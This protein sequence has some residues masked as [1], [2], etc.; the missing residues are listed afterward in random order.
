[1]DAQVELLQALADPTRLRL[2]NLLM[3]TEEVCVCELVD[4]LHLAQYNVSRHLQ[5]LLEVDLLEHR[6]SGKWIYYRIKRKLTPYQR[7]LL[8]AVEQLREEREEFRKDESRAVGRL[9]LRRNG[10][11]CVGLVQRIN[12]GRSR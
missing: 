2:L 5:A 7:T 6:R 11:C 3:Q 10:L 1:M 4:A 9:K 8:R 12:S